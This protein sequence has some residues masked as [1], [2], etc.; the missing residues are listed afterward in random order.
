MGNLFVLLNSEL[1]VRKNAITIYILD[2][3]DKTA[4]NKKMEIHRYQ[5]YVICKACLSAR[6]II[7]YMFLETNG[8]GDA[9]I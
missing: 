7:Y 8:D 5:V 3:W 9:N 1:Q 2:R 4:R 6:Y